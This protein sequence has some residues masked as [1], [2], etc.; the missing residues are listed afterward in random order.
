[1]PNENKAVAPNIGFVYFSQTDVTAQ[2]VRAAADELGS[3]DAEV[4][5]HQ[6]S[7]SEVI[8]G[9][10]VNAELMT[11]LNACDA[12]IFASPTYMGNVSGQF[13]AFADATSDFWESQAWTDKLAA[14]ITSGSAANGDQSTTLQYLLTFAC[15]HGMIWIGLNGITGDDK[16]MNRLGCN[17]GVTACSP[18]GEVHPADINSA[19]HLAR[20]VYDIASRLQRGVS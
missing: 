9:R 5:M 16:S 3:L 14:G 15:Q 11:R 20:R 2:L 10:F 1:M 12:I 7:G 8:N 19:K 13:K 18:D 6:I 17:L 4:L